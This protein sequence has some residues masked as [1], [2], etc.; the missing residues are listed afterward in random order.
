MSDYPVTIKRLKGRDIVRAAAKHNLREIAAE[1][2]AAGHIDP[3][4]I[5]TNLVLRGPASANKVAEDAKALMAGAGITRQRVGSV[6]ALE[7]VFTLPRNTSVNV[8]EYFEDSTRWAEEF[9]PVP[10]LSSVVHLDEA[11]P[12]CHILLLPIAEGHMIGSDL[13]GGRVKL[14]A[15]QASFQE[16]VRARHGMARQAPPKRLS[17][18]VRAEAMKRARECLESNSGLSDAVLAV[19][20]KPHAKDPEPLLLALGLSMPTPT[21]RQSFVAI[22]TRPT[23]PDPQNPIGK[24]QSNPIGEAG[25]DAPKVTL[26]YPCVGKGFT[27]PASDDTEQCKRGMTEPT[28]ASTSPLS[29]ETSGRSTSAADTRATDDERGADDDTGQADRADEPAE[30]YTRERDINRHADEWDAERGEWRLSSPAKPSRRTGTATAI[31]RQL[32]AMK[33]QSV[34]TKPATKHFC[35][36]NEIFEIRRERNACTQVDSRTESATGRINSHMGA[37]ETSNRAAHPGG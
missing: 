12:H 27:E 34:A 33:G 17:A 32:E 11:A 23:K 25:K 36:P 7:L 9:Y 24:A 8:R 21:P 15:M 2:G 35:T 3:A 19:L 20:L 37:M 18:A 22:M 31:Q 26:P 1:I 14:M 6:M 28:S 16:Q 10:V 29:T 4:R 13:H 30:R 5:H